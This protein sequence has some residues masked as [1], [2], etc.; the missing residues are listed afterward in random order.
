[1]GGTTG[2]PK[3]LPAAPA[4]DAGSFDAD[5][6]GL[7]PD[8]AATAPEPIS[9]EMPSLT[10]SIGPGR[11]NFPEDVWGASAIMAANGLMDAP[12]AEA[13]PAFTRA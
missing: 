1:M 12:T 7:I 3:D 4:T 10:G 13:G 11:D 9:F 8:F 2:G 6:G 5:T